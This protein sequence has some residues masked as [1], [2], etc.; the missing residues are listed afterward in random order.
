MS[1]RDGTNDY[2]RPRRP[3]SD[4]VLYLRGLPLDVDQAKQEIKTFLNDGG[5]FPQTLAA[6]FSAIDEVRMEIASLAGDEYGSQ[7]LEMLA[8]VSAPYSELASRI[9]LN[10]CSGYHLHLA[11]HRYG[12]HVL[13][14]ILQLAVSS[15]S[16]SDLAFHEESPPFADSSESLPSL[17]VLIEGM[18]E[19][20]SPHASQLAIHVCGSHVLR[21]L[22]CV[23]GGVDL[24]A[25]PGTSN[26]NRVESGAV[27]RGRKKGKKKK[28]KKHEGENAGMPH[29]GTMHIVYRKDSRVDAERFIEPLESITFALLGEKSDEP[30]DLQQLANHPSAGPLFIVLLRVLTYST[31]SGKRQWKDIIDNGGEDLISGFRLGISRREPTFEVDSLAHTLVRRILCWH[32]DSDDQ[33]HLGDIIFGLSGEPRGSHL[34]ETILRLSPNEIHEFI[35]KYGDFM[36]PTTMQEYSEHEVSNFVIQTLLTTIRTKEQAE[37][38]L[39]VV[40]KVISSGLAVAEGRRRRGILWRAAELAAKFR[41][42]QEGILKSVRLGFAAIKTKEDKIRSDEGKKKKERKKASAVEIKDCVKRLLGLRKPERDGD[43]VNLDAAGTRAIYHMLR[44]SPRLCEEVLKGCIDEQSPDDLILIIKDGLGSRCIMDG[45]LD[46]PIKTPI[47][48]GAA[49]VLYSKVTDNWVSLATDRVGHHTVKKLFSALPRIDD[50]SK[51]VDELARGGNRMNG[52]TMGRS[53]V[54]FCSVN[55]YKENPKSW[56]KKVVKM[57]SK[58]EVSFMDDVITKTTGSSGERQKAKRKRKRK[59]STKED[60]EQGLKKPSHEIGLSTVENIMEV[61]TAT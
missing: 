34:L 2:S 50:K 49:K 53:V 54:E 5:D 33:S 40:E 20:L 18:V 58:S 6:A 44:F 8:H 3:E 38:I 56:R 57:I 23:L 28:K 25:S 24:V 52:N 29:A 43:R 1:E 14:T 35:I 31:D 45:L 4:T 13:Q 32:E 51:L 59:R 39:K 42:G 41:V 7:S 27:L 15:S 37:S 61:M 60:L 46:G 17:A 9:L 30:G 12:S 48:A 11:T 26:E 21:T 36:S 22:L 16:D 19:E 55:E 47:F 10:A